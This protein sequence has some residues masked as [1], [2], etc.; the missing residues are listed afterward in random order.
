MFEAQILVAEFD[1]DYK[2]IYLW[3]SI[4][5]VGQPPYQF[6][7]EEQA[8]DMLAVFYPNVEQERLRVIPTA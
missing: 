3:K 5:P 2:I 7:T 6:E 8:R 1:A 4:H